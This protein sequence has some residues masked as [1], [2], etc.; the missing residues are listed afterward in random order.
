M[1]VGGSGG[2]GSDA[3]GIGEGDVG[4]PEA[5]AELLDLKLEGVREGREG[6]ERQ[7]RWGESGWRR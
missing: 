4:V 7:R 6:G 1:F 5:V 2:R 3:S